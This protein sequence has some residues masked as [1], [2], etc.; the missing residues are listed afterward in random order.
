MLRALIALACHSSGGAAALTLSLYHKGASAALFGT[1]TLHRFNFLIFALSLS[2]HGLYGFWISKQ[3]KLAREAGPSK[4][5]LHWWLAHHT[6]AGRA[7][8]GPTLT[9]SLILLRLLISFPRSVCQASLGKRKR[10][11]ATLAPE[12]PLQQQHLFLVRGRF[13]PRFRS[14]FDLGFT[15]ADSH[16]RGRSSKSR[17]S[18]E[19]HKEVEKKKH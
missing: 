7:M 18:F 5:C 3:S 1:V 11:H 9:L 6:T 8:F 13:L 10:A 17:R 15:L 16:C 12:L 2:A 19:L 4:R 14:H